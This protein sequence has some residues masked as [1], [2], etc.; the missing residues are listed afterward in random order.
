MKFTILPQT[1]PLEKTSAIVVRLVD[2]SETSQVVT[3]FTREFGKIGALAKGA[4]R[5]KGPFD[6]AL[7]LLTVC[8]IVFLHKSS[9]ALDILTEAK[10]VSRFR[11]AA[12]SLPH[13]Y[14]AYYI[15]ELLDALTEEG[16]PHEELFEAALSAITA[17]DEL[18]DV[19]ATVVRFELAALRILGHLPSVDFCTGCG[20]EVAGNGR[21]A[22]GQL[23]GGVLCGQ[24]REGQS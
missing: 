17:L 3:L 4:H 5:Q 21:V 13:L 24:C 9:D 7:D 22:F 15:A 14:A 2:F 6:S 8:R 20:V 12:T 16:D 1:M 18:A 11:S 19:G 10:M 23:S